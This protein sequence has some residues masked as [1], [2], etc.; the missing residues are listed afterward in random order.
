MIFTNSPKYQVE[1]WQGRCEL[2]TNH[3]DPFS[4]LLVKEKQMKKQPLT[5]KQVQ[6]IQPV[7]VEDLS[8]TRFRNGQI[9]PN[10]LPR[11]KKEW[12]GDKYGIKL[13]RGLSWTS[14]QK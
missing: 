1:G 13:K 4:I 7:W 12:Q 11:F 10:T 2:V 3:N 14:N 9:V 8:W 5:K 6:S